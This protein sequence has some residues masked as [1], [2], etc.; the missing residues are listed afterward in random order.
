[1]NKISEHQTSSSSVNITIV[2]YNRKELTEKTIMS[3]VSNIKSQKYIITVVDNAS[4]DGTY[5]LLQN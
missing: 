5:K 1:M 2:T 3:L 4:S